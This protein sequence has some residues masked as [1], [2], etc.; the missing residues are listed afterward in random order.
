[1]CIRD[2]PSAERLHKASKACAR[3]A[4]VT[5]KRPGLLLESVASGTIHRR[6]HLELYAL[7]EGLMAQLVGCL[8]YTSRCV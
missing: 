2:S 4:V 8:L 3:V 7:D 1:M 5:H 6:E